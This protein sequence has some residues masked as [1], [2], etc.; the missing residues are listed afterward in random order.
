[1]TRTRKNRRRISAL[2]FVCLLI[3]TS[4]T[5]AYAAKTIVRRVQF[6]PGT[7]SA[8]LK[9]SINH[10]EQIVYVLRANKGQTLKADITGTTPN[11]DVVFSIEGPGGKSLMGEE[12][13][14]YGT[15][16][17][18]RLPE[19]G[20]YRISIGMIESKSSQYTLKVSI[21]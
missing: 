1:M 15:S 2:A 20:D 14:D 8:V 9:G 3:V 16:W 19:T 18:G 10:M 11:N 7:S 4:I 12:G 5:P 6:R 21:H 17:S 13:D